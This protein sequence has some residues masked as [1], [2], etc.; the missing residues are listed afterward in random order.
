MMSSTDTYDRE[1]YIQN[2]LAQHRLTLI[3]NPTSLPWH[4]C[5]AFGVI[6]K[7]GKWRLIADFSAPEG[8]SVNDFID[9]DLCSLVERRFFL[10]GFS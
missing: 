4:Q 8:H 2:E 7:P 6:P 3:K 1:D 10:Q 9:R 5:N